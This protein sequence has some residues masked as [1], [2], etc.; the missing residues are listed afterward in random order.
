M[1]P[2]RVA[3]QFDD[4]SL[5]SRA[6]EYE[7]VP[8]ES[9]NDWGWHLRNRIY[10]YSGLCRVL[11]WHGEDPT[12]VEQVTQK[13]PLAITPYTA[14]E[15][16]GHLQERRL[17]DFNALRL[18]YIANSLEEDSFSAD[19]IDGTG[20][21]VSSPVP[22]TH[23]F[24]PDRVLVRLNS[25]C[26]SLCRYCYVRRKVEAV[27]PPI[28][29]D[30]L[31]QIAAYVKNNRN[32]RDVILS[33]GD[34]LLVSEE[35]LF[36]VLSRFREIPHVDILRIDTKVP[37]SL[38]QRITEELSNMLARFHPLY[39]NIHIAHPCEMTLDMRNACGRL[40]SQGV[41]L[42]A[43]IPLLKGINDSPTTIEK[44]VVELLR[45]RVR[46]YM[47]IQYIKTDGANHYGVPL[48]RGLEIME[49]LW[50]RVSG[51]AVPT[52]VLYLPRG[53]GKIPLMPQYIL[54]Q[55]RNL[56]YVKNW[57]GVVYQYEAPDI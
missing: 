3:P 39:V 45:N 34:P 51:L 1:E 46:P 42:G 44:L 41:I 19:A 43:H 12:S 32:I 25:M 28:P 52:F 48:K 37:N 11:D 31:A 23:R 40:A 33:G 24:F 8:E 10:D 36:S 26:P 4:A 57:R 16:W 56:L 35:F 50:G 49:H 54:K 22:Y 55:E 2:K 29:Q 5:Q 27:G 9:W 14:N 30:T 6:P 20:E 38:P 47:L 13:Y 15:M 53:G 18:I 17:D 21:D 7:G